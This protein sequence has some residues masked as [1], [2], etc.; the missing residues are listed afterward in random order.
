MTTEMINNT[1]TDRKFVENNKVETE[2]QVS[3]MN[4][5]WM[6]EGTS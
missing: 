6:A 3:G 4:I 1:R 5:P 2:I